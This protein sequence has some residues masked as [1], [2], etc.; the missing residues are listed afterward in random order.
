MVS[1]KNVSVNAG[2]G[3]G[4]DGEAD[5]SAGGGGGE[6]DTDGGGGDGDTDGGGAGEAEG[7]GGD[8]DKEGGG[9]DGDK[10]GGG[11]DGA[12]KKPA[13]DLIRYCHGTAGSVRQQQMVT[14]PWTMPS[15]KL[16][17]TPEPTR[18]KYGD[19]VSYAAFLVSVA[20]SKHMYRIWVGV[21][22]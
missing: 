10:E 14:C 19:P 5:G 22:A 9:G 2:A 7:G 11:G 20:P 12:A 8:G 16:G 18:L 15:N 13:P 21:A 17:L 6:G 4:G 1:S 3:D